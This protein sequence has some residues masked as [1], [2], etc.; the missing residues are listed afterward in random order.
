MKYLELTLPTPAENLALDEALLDACDADAQD[1]VLRVWEAPRPFVVLG[2]ANR[3][4]AEVQLEVCRADHLPILRRISG[5]GTVLQGPGCLSYALILRIGSHPALEGIRSTNGFVLERHRDA[6]AG[7]L[8]QPV[9]HRGDTDLTLG[10]RKFSGNAQRR[11]RHAVLLHGTFLLRFDL[12]QVSRYL[13]QPPRAPAYR[14]GR[15]H[16]EFVTNLELDAQAVSSALERAWGS[17]QPLLDIPRAQVH[18]LVERQYGR[19][20]W[21][22]RC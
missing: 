19:V 12:E 2:Y 21:N 16:G 1:E 7:L 14:A 9:R 4:A 11:K 8:G 15:A 18:T 13:R 5:G 17:D 3:V 20:D 6:L 10:D 22:L